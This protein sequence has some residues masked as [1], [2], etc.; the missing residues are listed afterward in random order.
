MKGCLVGD[1][2]LVKVRGVID[3]ITIKLLKNK[4]R[5]KGTKQENKRN[6]IRDKEKRKHTTVEMRDG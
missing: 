3:K 2:L 4:T 1:C 6:E 5:L